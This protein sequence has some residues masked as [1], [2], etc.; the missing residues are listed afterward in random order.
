MNDLLSGCENFSFHSIIFNTELDGFHSHFK[1]LIILN[2]TNIGLYYYYL[3]AT[4][5]F[6]YLPT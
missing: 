3:K 2:H 6:T 5:F 1:M 4:G